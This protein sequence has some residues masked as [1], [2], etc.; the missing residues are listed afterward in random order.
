M[1]TVGWI[2]FVLMGC[3]KD[4]TPPPAVAQAESSG[5]ADAWEVVKESSLSDLQAA[6]RDRA[7]AARDALMEKLKS[8]LMGVVSKDGVAAAISVCKEDAPQLAK[9]V[10]EE[11]RL[12]IGRTSFRLRNSANR[13]PDWAVAM[14]AEKVAEPTY[15]VNKDRFAAWLPIPTGPMCLNCHGTK[16]GIAT[17]VLTALEEKYPDDRATGFEEGDLRGWFWVE[18]KGP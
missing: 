13:P 1:L 5:D 6:Q 18:V 2:A 12:S 9:E 14:V 3:A 4:S 7:L 8:R 16:E 11:Q 17:D 15:L 10:S